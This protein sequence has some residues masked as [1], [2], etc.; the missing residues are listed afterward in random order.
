MNCTCSNK[1]TLK[2]YIQL[3]LTAIFPLASFLSLSLS[4]ILNFF[5]CLFFVVLFLYIR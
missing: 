2:N 5:V 3:V 4:H 1:N